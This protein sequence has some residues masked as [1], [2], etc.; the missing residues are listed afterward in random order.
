MVTNQRIYLFVFLIS[1]EK[2]NK[3]KKRYI[4]LPVTLA[5]DRQLA[6]IRK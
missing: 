3:K 5:G 1:E 4:Q 6:E 2:K